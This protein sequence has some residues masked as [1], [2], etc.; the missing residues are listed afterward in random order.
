[1][2][3]TKEEIM[4]AVGEI[5][6]PS[7]NNQTLSN[8]GAVKHLGFDMETNGVVLLV[9]VGKKVPEIT[10]PLTRQI[11]KIIKMDMGYSSLVVDFDQARPSALSKTVRI[12]GIVSGKGGVGKSTVAANLAYAL[13]ALNKSV[14]IIDADI[15]GA[16]MPKIL[17]CEDRDIMP[18][19]GEKLY[20]LNVDGIEMVSTE[21][22]VEKDRAL[23][24]RGPL[25]NKV[26]KLFFE[27]T[28]WSKDLD[29]LLID[30]PP[31]TGDVMMDIK[32]F[33]PDC[34]MLLITTPHPDAAHVAI[35][36][37]F[38]AMSLKEDLLG[39]VENMSYFE[40]DDKQYFIFGQGGGELV[41][42]KLGVPLFGKIPL[43]Q[44][45]GEK[46][47]IFKETEPIGLIYLALAKKIMDSYENN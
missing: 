27:D 22:F 36:A 12:I 37:G 7:R 42:K 32:N 40:V 15:Y 47:S 4:A 30:L 2:E 28:L 26:L 10:G 18:A 20:P 25:L 17:E 43:G 46:H 19:P 24:W 21:F 6:D 38:A 39:V 5:T 41:A 23:M 3:H 34:R 11:A 44:P 1:M 16:N 33:V 35:K 8:L 13:K 14:G 9:E 45:S 29:Y 31:G